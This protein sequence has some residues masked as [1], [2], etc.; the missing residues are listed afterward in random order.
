MRDKNTVKKTIDS[1]MRITMIIA[2]PAGFGMA[3]LSEQI[4]TIVYKNSNPDLIAVAAPILCVY[5]WATALFA[6]STPITNMLQGIGRTDIPLKSLV[7]GTV[8]KIISN[9]ILVGNPSINIKGA[10]IG[11]I[12]CYAIVVSINLVML[13]KVTKS[14][15]NFVSVFIKPLICGGL[16]ASMAWIVY[17]VSEHFIISSVT[18]ST[19]LAVGAAVAVYFISLLLIRGLSHDDIKML[20]KGEKIGKRLE[21][22]GLLE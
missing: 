20:P 14:K 5:G 21:K 10:P 12:L 4:F 17:N 19:V 22:Y 18:I 8:V 6:L 3:V 9:Y 13:I 11:S 2:V 16:S 1:V 15:V 7:I